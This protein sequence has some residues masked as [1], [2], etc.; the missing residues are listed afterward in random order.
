MLCP[1]K[2]TEK[3]KNAFTAVTAECSTKAVLGSLPST[4]GVQV[5]ESASVTAGPVVGSSTAGSR[6]PSAFGDSAS[7]TVAKEPAVPVPA[8]EKP[9]NYFQD[10][11]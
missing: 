11:I 1:W 4:S 9:G 2:F 10:H 3:L 6:V 5:P 8:G 7:T